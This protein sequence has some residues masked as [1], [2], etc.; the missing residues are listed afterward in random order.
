MQNKNEIKV[1]IIGYGSIGKRHYENL[2]KLDIKLFIYDPYI[3]KKK[4][5]FVKNLKELFLK[6]NIILISSPSELHISQLNESINNNKHVFVE[7]P[8]SHKLDGL[9]EIFNKA[10]KKNLIIKCG[11]NMRYRKVVIETKK[12]LDSNKL[13]KV[14]FANFFC[15]SF[16]PNWRP[17]QNY[18]NGY[19]NNKK[20]GGVLFDSIHEFDLANM[21]FGPAKVK[22]AFIVNTNLLKL[23]TEDF[24]EVN[25]I[26]S[27]GVISNIH[28]DYITNPKKRDIFVVG[29]KGTLE[30]DL[31]SNKILI[32][33]KV[34]KICFKKKYKYDL[35]SEYKNEIRDFISDIQNKK[36]FLNEQKR[37]I[38]VIK[39]IIESKK[40]D[41]LI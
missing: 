36:S 12:I 4:K 8:I 17:K 29:E 13:G 27:N 37:Y 34:N 26:H 30:V 16:L 23:K 31:V 20:G 5:E 38:E 21:F 19:A 3:K 35:N 18:L 32:K 22:K 1:G 2:K 41:N 9:N 40:S 14:I 7:K 39:Q 11:F 25:L 10:K 15:G 24:A 33:N 6:T 28:L